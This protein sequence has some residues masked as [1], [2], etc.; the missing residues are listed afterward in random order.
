MMVKLKYTLRTD[1]LFKILFTKNQGLLKMLVASL[2]GIKPESIEQFYVTNPEITAEE[3]GRKFCRLDINMRINGRIVDLEIQVSNE[4]NY[5]ERSLF[6]W[7]REFS[8]GINEGDDYTLLPSVV[9][10]SILGFNKFPHAKKFHS[11][12]QILEVTTHD[13]LTD[14]ME[15]H[16]YELK[17][18]P[19]LG[20]ADSDRDLWLKLF[21]A[22]T[23]EELAKIEAMEV[24]FM[25][26]AIAAYRHIAV[27]DEFV[28]MERMR[29]KARHDEAQALKNAT[30]AE[31]E[32][33]QN[34]VADKDAAL[35]D[36]DVKLADKDT[37]LANKDALIANKDVL[38]ANKDVELADKNV[39]LADKNALI[40]NL[41]A[42]LN[43]RQTPP[44]A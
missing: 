32:K 38:I 33:W 3:L 5:S 15:L 19:P 23:E 6:Y 9:I 39:E 27:S 44:S 13:L 25:S 17:K 29:S 7:A 4:G 2:L 16:F 8:T 22:E 24:P 18:L 30:D 43:S 42:E 21:N 36:K 11:K 12:F 28:T 37:A 40:A 14:K 34:V 1:T 41:Q 10:I 35:A 26:E 20:T 31:R